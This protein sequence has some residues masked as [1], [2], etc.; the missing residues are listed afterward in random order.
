MFFFWGGGFSVQYK[1]VNSNGK[2]RSFLVRI[3]IRKD[4]TDSKGF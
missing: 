3:L 4:N 1:T 2:F